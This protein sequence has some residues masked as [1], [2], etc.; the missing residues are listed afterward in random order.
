M[1][2]LLKF[3]KFNCLRHAGGL[4]RLLGTTYSFLLRAV[5]S[6]NMRDIVGVDGGSLLARTGRAPPGTL[7]GRSSANGFVY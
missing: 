1:M 2:L 5:F 3:R 4:S 6:M 7:K